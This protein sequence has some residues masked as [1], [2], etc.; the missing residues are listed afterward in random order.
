M[1]HDHSSAPGR[2]FGLGRRER[3]TRNRFMCRP[4]PRLCI[5]LFRGTLAKEGRPTW[6]AALD[7]LKRAAESSRL[8]D[9]EGAEVADGR[10]GPA[11][12]HPNTPLPP[13]RHMAR[14]SS[15][16]QSAGNLP[17]STPTPSTNRTRPIAFSAF[18]QPPSGAFRPTPFS[19]LLRELHG[20][21][22]PWFLSHCSRHNQALSA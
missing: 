18:S 5:V 1:C 13:V 9:Q 22:H 3:P 8:V 19:D 12:G 6:D 4:S 11:G 2:P 14:Q 15:R 7:R 10:H 21:G 17:P 16:V 20:A